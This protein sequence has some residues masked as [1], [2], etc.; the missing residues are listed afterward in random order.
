MIET[1]QN[2]A[3][4]PIADNKYELVTTIDALDRWIARAGE[5]RLVAF[6][7]ETTSLDQ[8]QA[9]L[10]GVSLCIEPGERVISHWRTSQ[11]T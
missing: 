4:V 2:Q 1:P 10:V 5:A 7:T 3:E 6:D 8:Q 11:A 9:E